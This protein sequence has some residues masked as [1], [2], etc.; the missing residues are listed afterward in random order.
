MMERTARGTAIVN[1]LQLQPDERIQAVIDTRD[2]ETNRYLFFVTRKGVGKKTLFNAYDSSRQAGLIAINLRD[3]DELVRVLP[4]NDGDEIMCVSQMGQGIRFAEADVRP[5]GRDADRCP[6][7]E[8]QAGRR[9]GLRRRGRC[10]SPVV[11]DHRRWLRQA[12]RSRA[13][14]PPGPWWPGRAC[15]ATACE[16]GQGRGSAH[17]GARGPA[18]PHR[19]FRRDHPC[20][21]GQHLRT[22][23]RC[24]PVSGS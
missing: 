17:G 8:A 13:V 1:L 4:A 18:V 11:V 19:R 15:H 9:G 2:Y 24:A 21:G 3:D 14:H 7:D 12:N 10:R 5:M 20:S 22:G 6:G 16:Q 23:S